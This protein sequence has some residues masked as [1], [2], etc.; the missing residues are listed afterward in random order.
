MEPHTVVGVRS[1]DRGG[2]DIEGDCSTNVS[3]ALILCNMILHLKCE[4]N[5]YGCCHANL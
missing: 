5:L 4:L 3:A 2:H 1:G